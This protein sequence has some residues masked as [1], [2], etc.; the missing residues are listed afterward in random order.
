MGPTVL[1]N[2]SVVQGGSGITSELAFF[3]I[4][5]VLLIAFAAIVIFVINILRKMHKAENIGKR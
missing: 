4:N 3:F 5:I 1:P 2:E